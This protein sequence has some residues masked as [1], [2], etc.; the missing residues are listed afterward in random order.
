[1][2]Y[3][4]L[5]M[6]HWS[7]LLFISWGSYIWMGCMNLSNIA[8]YWKQNRNQKMADKDHICTPYWSQPMCT[9]KAGSGALSTTKPSLIRSMCPSVVITQGKKIFMFVPLVTYSN[10]HS[11]LHLDISYLDQLTFLCISSKNRLHC[12]PASGLNIANCTT[13]RLTLWMP[14]LRQ[15]ITAFGQL[16]MV[17]QHVSWK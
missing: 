4:S 10:T 6:P 11:I 5:N 9:T 13:K 8:P 3:H 14:A 15:I 2:L 17:I 12:L 1:M 7:H 16:I